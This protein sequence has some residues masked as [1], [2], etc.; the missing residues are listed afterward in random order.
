MRS[1]L[2]FDS[3]DPGEY[4]EMVGISCHISPEYE[5]FANRITQKLLLR[6]KAR[7]TASFSFPVFWIL[8]SSPLDGTSSDG[9]YDLPEPSFAPEITA[10]WRDEAPTL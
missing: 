8:L 7:M 4:R 1:W 5:T 9:I 10:Q 3:L 6:A 2:V